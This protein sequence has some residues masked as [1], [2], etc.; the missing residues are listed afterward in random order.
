MDGISLG[1]NGGGL[2]SFAAHNHQSTTSNKTDSSNSVISNAISNVNQN[3]SY[4]QG[5]ANSTD[6]N[7][8]NDM[9]ASMGIGSQLNVEV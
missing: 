2:A 4:T 9:L 6:P 7:A 1:G 5:G 8:Q 3:H